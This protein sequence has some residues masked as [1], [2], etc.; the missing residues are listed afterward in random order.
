MFRINKGTAPEKTSEIFQFARPIK[1]LRKNRRFVS[2][3][4][5]SVHFGTVTIY[6]LGPQL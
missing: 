2:H 6:F 5:K 4:V 3:N 1:N